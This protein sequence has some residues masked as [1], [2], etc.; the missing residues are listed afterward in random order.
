M[1]KGF[2]IYNNMQKFKHILCEDCKVG[3][4]AILYYAVL[5]T[6]VS[7]CFNLIWFDLIWFDL[8]WFDYFRFFIR[9]NSIWFDLI[10]IYFISF[11][12]SSHSS[13]CSTLLVIPLDVEYV[14]HLGVYIKCKHVDI[15]YRYNFSSIIQWQLIDNH[16]LWKEKKFEVY[17]TF[18]C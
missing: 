18:I 15:H 8:I 9:S 17:S 11:Y 5:T 6:P 3:W 13:W 4:S 16:N 10:I 1:G 7:Y 14:I 12:L 2:L